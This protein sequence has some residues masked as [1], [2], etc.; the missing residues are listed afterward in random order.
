MANN[1]ARCVESG[2]DMANNIA[3]SLGQLLG[4][5]CHL[6]LQPL[7]RLKFKGTE[8]SSFQ[9]PQTVGGPN[10]ASPDSQSMLCHVAAGWT[11]PGSQG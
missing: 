5:L 8:N 2:P 3:T 4:H 7:A 11:L 10:V 9:W 6:L 1:Y